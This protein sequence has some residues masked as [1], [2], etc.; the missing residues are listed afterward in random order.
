MHDVCY[1]GVHVRSLCQQSNRNSLVPS[2]HHY[3]NFCILTKTKLFQ[4]S[5]KC[6]DIEPVSSL[7]CIPSHHPSTM[8]AIA[9]L[10]RHTLRSSTRLPQA[11]QLQRSSLLTSRP[12]NQHQAYRPIS[13]PT[14]HYSSNTDNMSF[15]NT[16]TGNKPADP[17]TATNIQDPG[18]K[19]KVE[20]LVNFVSR[21]KFCMM[22]TETPNGLLASRCMALAAKVRQNL[23][24]QKRNPDRN[25]ETDSL[26][27]IGGSRR[28]L[29]L[30][31]QL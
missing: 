9:P 25:R 3:D 6:L 16:D 30:P 11:R 24:M 27:I 17:Y 4:P 23:P 28:R 19:E 21:C 7:L 10:C 26:P 8:N 15:S 13:F 12:R 29:H 31:R 2:L 20:D 18:L 1:S 14:R 5:G 22:T